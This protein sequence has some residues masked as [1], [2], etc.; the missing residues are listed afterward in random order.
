MG[1]QH[2][3]TACRAATAGLITW[4][5]GCSRIGISLQTGE[6]WLRKGDKRLPKP[7]RIGRQRFF[8]EAE[9]TKKARPRWMSADHTLH[10]AA[11]Q[12]SVSV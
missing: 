4:A 7:T 8:L 1:K 10:P 9:F 5:E 3:P 6:R 2:R 11:L 12:Q